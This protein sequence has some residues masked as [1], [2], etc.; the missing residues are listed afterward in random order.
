MLSNRLFFVF[1]NGKRSKWKNQ[2]MSYPMVVFWLHYS[3]TSSQ[4]TNPYQKIHKDFFMQMTFAS[5]P[6]TNL[7]KWL[8]SIFAR[9]Y[10]SYP[11]TTKTTKNTILSIS[12]TQPSCYSQN[13]SDI[14]WKTISHD[15][16]PVYLGVTMVR[17]LSFKEHTRKLKAKI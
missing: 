13:E 9:H 6:K 17:T 12:L 2:K 16:Y 3:L 7:L 8:N 15:K 14:E 4:M 10:Q 5:P 11:Y 1:P